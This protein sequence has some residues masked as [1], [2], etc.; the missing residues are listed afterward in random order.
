MFTD[1]VLASAHHVLVFMLAAIIAAEALI[2]WSELSE[3]AVRLLSRIDAYYGATAALVLLVGS[4]RILFGLK[5][6]EAYVYNW[7]FWLK[8]A[9]FVAVG[10]LSISPTL[11]FRKW[12]VSVDKDAFTVSTQE[13][14]KVRGLI[15]AQ[16]GVFTLIPVLAA[17]MARYGY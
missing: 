2:V 13:I 10:L 8:I 15:L 12:R 6:W 5:G 16:I 7:A 14:T 4:G 1:L 17:T 3:A 11:Q 9:A